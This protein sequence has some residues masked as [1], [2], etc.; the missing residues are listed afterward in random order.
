MKTTKAAKKTARK[1]C[2]IYD[3]AHPKTPFRVVFRQGGKR[4]QKWF[5]K[6]GDA[7]SFADKKDIELINAGVGDAA[8]SSDERQALTLWRE[9]KTTDS[10]VAVVQAH[11]KRQKIS[12]NSLPVA[13]AV[14]KLIDK[15][16]AESKAR[17]T[18]TDLTSR[19]ERFTT[20]IEAILGEGVKVSEITIKDVDKWLA[21]L[22]ET[23]S[24]QSV[25]NFRR[26]LNSLFVE[27]L[28][29]GWCGSNPV[30]G[31]M[32]PTVAHQDVTIYTPSEAA[33]LLAHCTPRLL[34]LVAIGLFAGLR[35]AEVLAL[36]WEQVE[37][38]E[39]HIRLTRTKTGRPRLVPMADNL[40]AWLKPYAQTSGRLWE[41]SE[42]VFAWE[43]AKV[44]SDAG[45]TSDKDNAMRHSFGSYRT[46]ITQNVAQV[47]LEM[48]NTPKM[49]E[50]HY[51]ELVTAKQAKAFFAVVPATTANNVI[52][53]ETAA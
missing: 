34:P 25:V 29:Q 36:K 2:K 7:E 46:A 1:F 43:M 44:R 40:R 9:S 39:G 26:V 37:L 10:L 8:L 52:P 21:M 6:K 28:R 53:M 35:T 23:Q 41:K 27:A 17:R 50:N 48:G 13:L 12:G 33:D 4:L 47:A 51:R 19:L 3:A 5:A 15:R 20:D 42:R 16:R 31:S 32:K 11:L 18:L 45:I 38:A 24:P 49:V 22:G 14:E 30:T